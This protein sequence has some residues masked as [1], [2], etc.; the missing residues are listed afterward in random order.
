MQAESL[1]I[2]ITKKRFL[3]TEYIEDELKKRNINPLR[4]AVVHV[5][6][7]MYTVSV[8]N[9]KKGIKK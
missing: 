6:D 5:S 4:W 1:I 9:L 7:N 2:E 3:T 8:T